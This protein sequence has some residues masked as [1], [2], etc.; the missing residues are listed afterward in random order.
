M[1]SYCHS[2]GLVSG[3][4]RTSTTSGSKI[5]GAFSTLLTRTAAASGQLGT[6]KTSSGPLQGSTVGLL[7]GFFNA[8]TGVLD[9][10]VLLHSNRPQSTISTV[11]F[12]ADKISQAD[13]LHSC[14]THG[15]AA[16]GRWSF[17]MQT[18]PSDKFV[19]VL[20]LLCAQRVAIAG[21]I[22]DGT[23][24]YAISGSINAEPLCVSFMD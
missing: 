16:A 5:Q 11:G 3:R 4:Y 19:P 20:R 8:N 18:L 14:A 1:P 21:V 6:N 12:Y 17:G 10:A 2:A 9:Y 13:K 7:Q 23:V 22:K 15:L 24:E